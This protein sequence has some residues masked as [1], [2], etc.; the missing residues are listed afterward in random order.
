MAAEKQ[1]KKSKKDIKIGGP[2]IP[3]AS[4]DQ[5][6]HE[7][8]SQPSDLDL[9]KNDYDLHPKFAKFKHKGSSPQ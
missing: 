8:L 6:I 4:L 7:G 2:K 1:N 9:K 3:P 5:A